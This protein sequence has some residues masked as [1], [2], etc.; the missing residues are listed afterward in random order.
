MRFTETVLQT[1]SY[2]AKGGFWSN[3]VGFCQKHDKQVASR[4]LKFLLER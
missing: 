4:G 2:G 3:P 1:Y